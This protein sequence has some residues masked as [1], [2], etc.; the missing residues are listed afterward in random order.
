MDYKINGVSY[1][2]KVFG[3]GMENLGIGGI[4]IEVNSESQAKVFNNYTMELKKML[5]LA[6]EKF[7]YK[8][9]IK[10]LKAYDLLLAALDEMKKHYDDVLRPYIRI[11]DERQLRLL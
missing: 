8:E 7:Q 4:E 11:R 6:F 1:P 5:L 10:Y 9:A 3:F 2:E